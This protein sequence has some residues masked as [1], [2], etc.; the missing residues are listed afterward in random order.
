MMTNKDSDKI[1]SQ[2]LLACLRNWHTEDD[3]DGYL[4]IVFGIET[5]NAILMIERALAE[6]AEQARREDFMDYEKEIYRL[7][8]K[9]NTYAQRL[10]LE[11]FD[12]VEWEITAGN[13]C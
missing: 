7:K 5:D 12:D 11:G 4:D 3:E 9:C 1:I 10:V 8:V 6:S 13:K 2:E